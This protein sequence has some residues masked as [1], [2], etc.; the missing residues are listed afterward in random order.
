MDK[1]IQSL[2]FLNADG[3][4]NWFGKLDGVSPA[5][6][7]R[8]KRTSNGFRLVNPE[9]D[10]LD[11]E[12]VERSGEVD[13]PVIGRGTLTVAGTTVDVV[14]FNNGVGL[15]LDIAGEKSPPATWDW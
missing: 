12:R 7:L 4:V 10:V 5:S 13:R 15:G 6:R 2:V 11:I 9:G 3:S 14:A 8:G 1:R